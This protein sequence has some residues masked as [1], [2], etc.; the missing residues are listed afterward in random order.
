MK[1]NFLLLAQ[2]SEKT[3]GMV[4]ARGTVNKD[5]ALY[6][7]PRQNSMRGS[8]DA[9]VRSERLDFENDDLSRLPRIE[10]MKA[11]A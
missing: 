1:P 6:V 7:P 3:G 11:G 5:V 9:L 8:G 4:G 10:N 2:S